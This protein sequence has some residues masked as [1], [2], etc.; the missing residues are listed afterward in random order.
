MAIKS[1]RILENSATLQGGS[2]GHWSD[3]LPAMKR[4]LALLGWTLAT[5][6]EDLALP[7]ALLLKHEEE[8]GDEKGKDG[9]A[10][11]PHLNPPNRQALLRNQENDNGVDR[12]LI[13]DIMYVLSVHGVEPE[14][15]RR[16]VKT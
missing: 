7:V 4:T 10:L 6:D 3:R 11:H 9:D 1:E 16:E 12:I 13:G 5:K 2:A 15:S 8:S 14:S